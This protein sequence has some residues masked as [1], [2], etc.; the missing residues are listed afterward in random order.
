MRQA[1]RVIDPE[2]V[3]FNKMKFK[4]D[5]KQLI[6][7]MRENGIDKES[8]DAVRVY[9]AAQNNLFKKSPALHK[10]V[11]KHAS[12]MTSS[13]F[14]SDIMGIYN[15]DTIPI[16]TYNRMKNDSQVAIGLATIKMP[17]YSLNW[18]VE[19]GDVDIREFVHST[20][21]PIWNKLLRSM[22]TSIDFGFASH[23][24]VWELKDV[25]VVTEA[26]RKKTHFKGKA[27]VYKKIKAHY[28]GTIKIRTDTKTDDFLGIIQ[29]IGAGQ[30]IKLDADKCFLFSLGDEFG[31]FF[32][33]SRLKPA[34]KPWYWK[35]VL[36]Q[37]MLRYFE[38]RGSPATVVHHPIGGGIDLVGNEYENS[39]IALR[40]GQ[41]IVENSVVTLPYEPDKNGKNQWGV[42][43]LE[44]ERRGEMFVS[45]LS[46]LG[47]QILR[48]LLTPERVVTQDLSTGSFSMANS[49]AEIFLLSQEGLTSEIEYAINTEIIPQ[50]V[51]YNFKPKKVVP[52]T[53]KI[54][55]IQYD[56][57]RLLK[58]IYVEMIRNLNNLINKGTAPSFV[59]SLVDM[60]E[61]LGIPVRPFDE[62]YI[63]NGVESAQGTNQ[64]IDT[65]SNANQSPNKQSGNTDSN[66]NN[67]K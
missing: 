55:K 41:N 66:A 19:C 35:E 62:E 26:P 24:K 17:I 54:E 53:I 47:A 36:S 43:Y 18:N 31:N 4:S 11:T 22:L 37:F 32:G 44:D 16:S 58:E 56:R 7:L 25:N 2:Y 49:H 13:A 40:I 1:V 50:L 12:P 60:A 27:E 67:N 14:S 39:E 5:G 38:R 23:E 30:E 28:P 64:N 63:Y 42:T 15:P 59:P 65:G 10:E 51:Y 20:L 34:Y 48:A 52:C 46:Y 21:K 45:A 9:L 29:S 57:K 8:R 61:V 33:K 3:E 6:R